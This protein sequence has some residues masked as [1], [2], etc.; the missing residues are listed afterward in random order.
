MS[1][2]CESTKLIRQDFNLDSRSDEETINRNFENYIF[3]DKFIDFIGNKFN[4]NDPVFKSFHKD[5]SDI[6][7][8]FYKSKKNEFQNNMRTSLEKQNLNFVNLLTRGIISNEGGREIL[9]DRIK[10]QIENIKNE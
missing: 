8:K 4:I 1:G 10:N 5:E 7:E 2:D 6:L 9:N 3:Q